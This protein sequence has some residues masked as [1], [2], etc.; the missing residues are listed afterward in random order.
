MKISQ[1]CAGTILLLFIMSPE[2]HISNFRVTYPWRCERCFISHITD[3]LLCQMCGW[4]WGY[5]SNSTHS[6]NECQTPHLVDGGQLPWMINVRICNAGEKSLFSC[7][8]LES[9]RAHVRQNSRS[10]QVLTWSVLGRL[11]YML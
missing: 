11:L 2:N 3:Y 6:R 10:D 8:W 4:Y 9:P 1:K 7:I 5:N